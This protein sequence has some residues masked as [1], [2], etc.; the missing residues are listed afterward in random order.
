MH[1][2]LDA[3][4]DEKWHNVNGHAVVDAQHPVRYSRV[5]Y[6]FAT[7]LCHTVIWRVYL[8]PMQG[9][10]G[11]A[12]RA[13]YFCVGSFLHSFRIWHFRHWSCVSICM[14]KYNCRNTS[15]YIMY[16][17]FSCSYACHFIPQ[18]WNRGPC[19]C[20][21]WEFIRNCGG[22]IKITRAVTRYLFLCSYRWRRWETTWWR[23]LTTYFPTLYFKNSTC[24]ICRCFEFTQKG[25]SFE[26]AA[27][28]ISTFIP[29]SY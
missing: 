13:S 7:G 8:L 23:L 18:I 9:K 26:L 28:L 3:T 5:V 4:I 10:C 24:S 16:S 20:F 2:P 17:H 22:G 29:L 21:L 14:W 1:D 27:P 11:C 25:A 19:W 12:K 15:S 6:Y